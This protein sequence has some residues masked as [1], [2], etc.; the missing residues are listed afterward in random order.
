[1]PDIS[2]GSVATRLRHG[3]IFIDDFITNL[4]LIH[5]MKAYLKICQHLMQI[6]ALAQVYVSSFIL[7]L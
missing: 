2:Q 4:L 3:D 1:V 6:V 7:R 5:K